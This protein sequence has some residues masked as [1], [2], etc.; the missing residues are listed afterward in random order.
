MILTIGHS[1]HPPDVFLELLERHAVALLADVRSA[2]YSRLHPQFRKGPLAAVLAARGIGYAHLGDSLGGRPKDASCYENGRVRYDRMAATEG[3]RAGLQRLIGLARR[4]RTV[5]M[6]AEADPLHCHRALLV[7]PALDRLGID[8]RHIH[9]ADGALE[10]HAQSMDR[11]LERC[12]LAPQGDL[13]ATRAASIAQAID[14][15][16]RRGRRPAAQAAQSG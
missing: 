3:F 12:G 9:A 4:R 6:C 13:L 1:N 11:L 2:P 15:A 16:S 14:C 7:A 8:V 10:P 5:L